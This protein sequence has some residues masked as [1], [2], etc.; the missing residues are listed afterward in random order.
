[1]KVRLFNGIL[2]LVAAIALIAGAPADLHLR[3]VKAEPAADG[4]V[5]VAPKEIRLF[6]SQEPEIRATKVIVTNGAKREITVA[7]AQADKT[8]GK[9]VF[10]QITGAIEP[11]AYTVVWRTMA[12]DGHAVNGEFKFTVSA[13]TPTPDN[14]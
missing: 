14:Q 12:K 3:L 5:T 11:G 6:F 1:M 13:A 4:A 2:V 8:D 7:A 9:I 10:A